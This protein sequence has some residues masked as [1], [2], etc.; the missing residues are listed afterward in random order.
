MFDPKP[1][2]RYKKYAK[3]RGKKF[4]LCR[5]FV[6]LFRVCS[7]MLHALISHLLKYETNVKRV[8]VEQDA[9]DCNA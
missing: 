8:N 7:V 3:K 1:A 2:R 4:I 9:L 5:Q 6:R